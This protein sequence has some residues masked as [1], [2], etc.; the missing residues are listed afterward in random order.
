MSESVRI[1]L[2]DPGGLAS[3]RATRASSAGVGTGLASLAS[4]RDLVVHISSVPN[5][6]RIVVAVP[7]LRLRRK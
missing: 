7:H 2:L 1:H 3:A 6:V 4:L 5:L